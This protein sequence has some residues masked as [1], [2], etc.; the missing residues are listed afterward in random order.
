MTAALF[1]LANLILL[2]DGYADAGLPVLQQLWSRIYA[3]PFNLIASLIFLCA[4]IH[5]FFSNKIHRF[6]E[7]LRK[8][9]RDS[10]QSHG[11]LFLIHIVKFCGEIEVVFGLW[12]IPLLIC[13]AASYGGATTI[14]YLNEL[15]YN[16]PL[17]VIIIM[18]IASTSPII[19]LA[20]NALKGLLSIL[21]SSIKMQWMLLLTIGPLLG[22]FITEPAAM[23]LTALLLAKQFYSCHPS[24]KLAYATL[25]LL[26]VNVSVGG[27][28][29]NFA[30]PPVLMVAMKWGWST[31][32][33]LRDFGLNAILGII[34]ANTFYLL[35]FREEFDQMESKLQLQTTSKQHPE[36]EPQPYWVTLAH[37]GFLL[38]VIL[39]SRHPTLFVAVFLFFLGFY[40]ASM[41]HQSPL[42]IKESLLV[43][44]FLAGLVV[45]ANLQGW[46]IAP[47]LTGARQETVMLIAA[48]L[49]VF[50]DNAGVT[51]LTTLV[52][53][54]SDELKRAVISG[55]VAGG[56]LTVMA[57]APNPVG[58]SILEK[59]FSHG[60]AP[61]KLALAGLIPTVIML[62]AF[63]FL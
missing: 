55:A 30:A 49:S 33:M 2:P 57:N 59:H 51:Y 13:M 11:R 48:A 60:I 21:G 18:I 3:Q 45:H 26:F 22:S 53:D 63:Y 44:F 17:F 37:I 16:E 27:V 43:G 36:E 32:Y 23:T 15:S 31:L 7:K 38:L 41:R 5:I 52:P 14:Q 54:F 58:H 50:V 39:C 25:G 62:L 9:K 40:Q 6:S 56:G 28:L 42:K 29:T 1:F 10:E 47:L 35:W 19:S 8:G 12:A 61:A 4:I 20:T 34:M 46:W 24:R